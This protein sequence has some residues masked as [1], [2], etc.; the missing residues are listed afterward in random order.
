MQS[1]FDFANLSQFQ[2]ITRKFESHL[3]LR[4][5]ERVVFPS[6]SES[7]ILCESG[8]ERLICFVESQ[9]YVLQDL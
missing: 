5:G 3:V 7:G 2:E 1:D 8:K 9:Y 4:V 6:A